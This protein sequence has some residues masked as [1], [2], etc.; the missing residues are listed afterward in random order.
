MNLEDMAQ[1]HEAQLWEERNSHWDR[2]PAVKNPG[3]PGYGPAECDDCG[4][5]M[6]PVRRRYGFKACTKCQSEV[7]AKTSNR[8]R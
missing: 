7:E 2:Q 6:H 5:D 1:Q 4:E 3:D 8:I